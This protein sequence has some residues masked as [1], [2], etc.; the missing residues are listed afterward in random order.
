MTCIHPRRTQNLEAI[1][2]SLLLLISHSVYA[3]DVTY[4][5]VDEQIYDKP[6]KTQI[7]QHIVVSG[8][9]SK[10]NL[11]A[12]I[13]KRYRAAIARRGFQYHNPATNIY[14]Y[15]YGTKEQARAGQGL[16]IGMLAKSYSDKEVPEVLVSDER[17]AALS[18]LP[19]KR[20]GLSESKR[21]QVFREIA[22]AEDRATREAMARIPNTQ[23]M[24]QIDLERKL[25]D[26]YKAEVAR[27]HGLTKDLLLKISAEGVKNGWPAP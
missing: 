20:Y 10:A 25:T 12:E 19:E 16:W 8:V 21:K 22:K 26:K 2:A 1:I 4:T 18:A 5:L 17:L 3:G 23:I 11:K 9:P 24:K 27:K 6:I 15:V 7:E 14:I 13:L